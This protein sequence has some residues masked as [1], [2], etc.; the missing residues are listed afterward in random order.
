MTKKSKNSSLPLR[1]LILSLVALCALGSQRLVAQSQQLAFIGLH[2]VASQGQFNAVQSD[3]SGN[4]YLLL[5]QKDGVR[6]LKTDA[7]ATNLIAQAHIGA[8]GDIGLAMALDPIGNLYITG[9]TTSNS[10]TTTTAAAFPTPTGTST[11]SFVAKFDSNLNLLFVTFTGTGHIAADSIAATATSV[12]I[13][14]SIFAPTLPVTPSAIIQ[15]PASPSSQNGFVEKFNSTGTTLLYATYLSGASGNT[16]PAAIAADPADNAYIVGYTSAPG[17]PTIAALIPEIIPS[18]PSATSGFLTKLTPNGD[19]IT[20][21]TFIPGSG[22]TSITYDPA[23]QNLLLSGSIALGDFPIA[24]VATPLVPTTYQT[25]LR[26]PT[27]GSTV[28]AST[29]IAPGTQSFATPA[30]NGAAWIT[31]SL[32]APL[33]P[34]SPLSNIGNSFAA[35]VIPQ[36]TVDQTARFGGLPASNPTFASAPVAF[37]SLTT[38]PTSQPIFAGSV[39]PTASSSL[40]ATQTYNLPLYNAPTAALPSSLR[41]AALPAGSC[42]GSICPGSAA[43]LAKLNTSLPAPSLALSYDDAPNLT[44]RNLGSVPATGLQINATN[45]T[46]A[47]NCTSILPAGGECNIALTGNGPGSITLQA[48]N[49]TSQSIN[50]PAF[51]ATLLPVVFSP[52]ELDFGIQTST[53]KPLTRTV[54]ITNLTQ[55]PQTFNSALSTAS[56]TLPYTLA[57]QASDCPISG[58]TSSKLLAPGG[59]CHITLALS[60]SSA[61]INDGF[62]QANWSIGSRSVLVTAYTQAAALSVSAPLIDFGTFYTGS[63]TLPRY[64]YL[65]N[66]SDTAIAHTSVS[67]IATS[68]FTVTDACPT[69]LLP[70]TI[71]QLQLT[72][73]SAAPPSFDATTLTLDQGLTVLVTGRT[74]PQPG[75]NGTSANPNLA[76]TPLSINFPNAVV[77]TSTSSGTQTVTISNTGAQPFTLALQLTDDFTDAS[78][79]TATLPGNS[80]CSVVLTFA[81]SQPGT[82]QGLLAITAGSNTTPVFV[83]L[84]GIGTPILTASNGTIDFGNV[85]VGQPSVQWFKIAQP[86]NSF[87]AAIPTADFTAILVEDIGYGHG[88]PPSSAFSS[89]A[90][91]TCIN[92]WLGIQFKP[93]LIAPQTATLSLISTTSG[94]PSILTLTGTG[95]PLTGL[96]L[97]PVSQDFGPIPIHSTSDATLFTLTNLTSNSTPI[98]LTVPALTGDFTFITTP[99]GGATCTGTLAVNASCFLQIA[100][101][102][103]A[104]GPRSGTLT[105]PTTAGPITTALTGYGAPDPGLALNPTALIFKNVPGIGS[106][107]TATRQTISLT[108]TGT[109]QLQIATPTVTNSNF[110]STST[111]SSLSPAAT[112]TITIQFTPSTADVADVLQIPVISI[113]GGSPT[114]TTYTVPLAGAYT[115]EDSGLQII[116]ADAQFGPNPTRTLG[117]TRQFTINNLTS[118]SLYLTLA[119]PRQFVLAGPPCAGLAPYASCSF[120]ATFL[121]LT[122]GDIT[123]TLFAQAYPTDASPTLSALGYVEGYG[124]GTNTL[125]VTGNLAPGKLLNFGQVASGQSATQTLTLTNP[126]NSTITVR[127]IT[128]EWPFL[129]SSTCGG[130]LSR[131]QSCTVTVT[132]NPLNQIAVGTTSPLS[133]TDAGTLVVESDALSSPDFIDLAGSA[134]PILVAAPSNTA[135]LISY[136]AS[137]SSLTFPTTLVGNA[138]ASQTVTLANTGTTTLHI[139]HLQTSSDFTVAS[140][141][142]TIVPGASCN[143][144]VT[145]TPQSSGTRIGAIE[146]SSDASTSLEF[147]TLIGAANPSF[148]TLTPAALDFG[149]VLV[150]NNALLPL[151]VTN[152]AANPVTFNSIA[153]TGDYSASGTCLGSVLPTA[154]S[155]TVQVTF[156]PTQ[157]GPRTGVLSIASS[158]STLPLTAALTGIGAQSHLQISPAALN[159][160]NIT[161]GASANLSLIL[162]NTGNASLNNLAL[163]LSTGDFNLTTPCPLT[164]LAPG[165]T[166]TLMLTFT[167]SIIGIRSNTLTLTSSDST[168]PTAIPLLGTG[169][170]NGTFTLTVDGGPTS[171]ATVLSGRPAN[172]TLTVTPQNAFAGTVI[173][174][175]TPITPGPNATCSLIPSSITLSGTA[176]N[177]T[178]TINTITS[179]NL[180]SQNAPTP[181]RNRAFLSL[182]LPALFLFWRSRLPS[183]FR[184]ILFAIV[185]LATVLSVN[186]CGSGGDPSIRYTP[187]G[188]YQYQVTATSTT[189]VQI[190]QSVTLNLIV[191]PK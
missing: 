146:I 86:F 109:T 77:V 54:T 130:T 100:F 21:S 149:T 55:L 122:N 163:T 120:T 170:A 36:G 22:V 69:T 138:S 155:C 145:F 161:V 124:L 160:G 30:N 99:T 72:Y 102:P 20:F 128:S 151:Q 190:T 95:L 83:S 132:Y 159:F 88:Q 156:A 169:L 80:S 96:I 165:A 70:R 61:P 127:R 154:T 111:C 58:L 79:C 134:T 143:L 85:V 110:L 39:S 185:A 8:Q 97:A 166:C 52:K 11:N 181:P 51:N 101:A 42:S 53:S 13:T 33:L 34:L 49:A 115:T 144:I 172:Y 26:I 178:A 68:P 158:T 14:G 94:L 75:A 71:C 98:T 78:N 50:L 175:C 105:L 73:Q 180:S 3:P 35:H 107:S 142:T 189:G 167:P 31:G 114:L 140:A 4:L 188:T 1:L 119:F 15:T 186:G 66:P 177:S 37:T 171:S 139:A 121:P 12:F 153:A 91:G 137:Q 38:D 27:D 174:N 18:T 103:T 123:G 112:C 168:S 173:L 104:S 67:T 135:P 32:T 74:V 45:F 183:T 84:T 63:I 182:L 9:T 82:R 187:P 47:T 57:E 106:T 133:N 62:L 164:S 148:L 46:T 176:Q 90:T 60:A 6:L 113:I 7:A 136:V 157:S 92:C 81:P 43:Y 179:V 126:A 162:T 64:L 129:S 48:V 5:D 89:T 56:Q 65:S 125:S 116:P 41:G 191:Q 184:K 150:G 87:T 59:T 19:G 131:N 152:T 16:A 117:S 141:C 17:Y 24:N 93:S 147:I 2:A 76:V 28:L 10:L 44:L 23:A 40:L 29:L 25:S 108:N 118:K